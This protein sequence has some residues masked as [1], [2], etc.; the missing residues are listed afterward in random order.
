[1]IE[2]INELRYT[3]HL[4]E[5]NRRDLGALTEAFYIRVAWEELRDIVDGG[6]IIRR[7]RN[8]TIDNIE[9]DLLVETER[10]IYIV[11]VKIQPNHHD[12]DRLIEKARYIK[13]RLKKDIK[14][15]LAGTWIG[16]EV[17]KYADEKNIM[18]LIV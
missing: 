8:F 15:V 10:L 18:L 9:V 1:M 17:R 5:L 12:V 13:D 6:K 3:R 2:V 14:P 7:V 11:E 4:A 16:S